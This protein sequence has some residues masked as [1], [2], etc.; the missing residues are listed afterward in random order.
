MNKN[1]KDS[2]NSDMAMKKCI[3]THCASKLIAYMVPSA[4]VKLDKFPLN[5]NGKVDRKQLP[6]PSSSNADFIST[7]DVNTSSDESSEFILPLLL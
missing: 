2:E 3:H 1:K 6:N 4:Y 5:S 7:D